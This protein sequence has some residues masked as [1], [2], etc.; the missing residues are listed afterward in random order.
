MTAIIMKNY[1]HVYRLY[2]ATTDERVPKFF[3]KNII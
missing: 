2:T 1:V 3:Y